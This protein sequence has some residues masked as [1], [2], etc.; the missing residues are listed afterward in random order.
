[1]RAECPEACLTAGEDLGDLE[2]NLSWSHS[3]GADC[4]RAELPQEVHDFVG[5]VAKGENSV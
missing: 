4:N 5:S 2:L 1:M 3:A